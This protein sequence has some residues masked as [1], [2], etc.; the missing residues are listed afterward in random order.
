MPKSNV[1]SPYN[2]EYIG[3]FLNDKFHGKG[4]MTNEDGLIYEGEWQDGK[5]HGYG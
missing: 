3:E 5:K 4:K 2:N 1:R